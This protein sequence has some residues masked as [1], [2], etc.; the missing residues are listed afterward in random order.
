MTNPTISLVV[1]NVIP[2]LIGPS[3]LAPITLIMYHVG[4][5][6]R[7]CSFSVTGN[8]YGRVNEPQGDQFNGR[9]LGMIPKWVKQLGCLPGCLGG[10]CGLGGRGAQPRK[11]LKY[12]V[13]RDLRFSALWYAKKMLQYALKKVLRIKRFH[14]NVRIRRWK[15]IIDFWLVFESCICIHQDYVPYY[16]AFTCMHIY[17]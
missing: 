9:K 4:E 8:G 16:P 17:K 14:P 15:E 1:Y 12:S 2:F 11:C 3:A 13:S 10:R 5:R 7:P 6:T